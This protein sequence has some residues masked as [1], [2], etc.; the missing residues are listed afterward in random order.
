MFNKKY[1]LEYQNTDRLSSSILF[2]KTKSYSPS[3]SDIQEIYFNDMNEIRLSDLYYGIENGSDIGI[4]Y[5]LNSYGYRGPSPKVTNDILTLGCSQTFG[6]GIKDYGNTWPA[7]VSY[8]LNLNYTNL[9]KSGSSID[10]QIR[11]AFAYFKKF[12]NPKHIFAIFPDFQRVEFP[13]NYKTLVADKSIKTKKQGGL[14][15]KHFKDFDQIPKV[16]SMPHDSRDIFTEELCYFRSAQ[17]ILML[18]QYCEIAGI[19][20]IWGTWSEE[21]EDLILKLK[22]INNSSYKNFIPLHNYKWIR[23]YE[24]QQEEFYDKTYK[25]LHPVKSNCHNEHSSLEDF[26][27]ALD[28]KYNFSTAHSGVHRHMHWAETIV[29]NIK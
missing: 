17:S 11:R 16:S 15:I 8:S 14:A 23:N 1:K 21:D 20:F 19:N 10:S 7:I 5:Q 12:G 26:Y 3:L 25:D 2:G 18:E 29:N 6:I 27:I 24:T 13:S 28:K 22:E 9:A 4:N